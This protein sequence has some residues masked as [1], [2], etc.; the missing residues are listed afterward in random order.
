MLLCALEDGVIVGSVEA[1]TPAFLSGKQIRFWNASVPL[2]TY[3][4]ALAV[5]PASRRSGVARALMQDVEDRA[6][7]IAGEET[8]SNPNPNPNPDPNPNPNP[9]PDPKP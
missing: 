1:F 8:V 4:T 2:E 7:R 6:F 3:V 5:A 9:N